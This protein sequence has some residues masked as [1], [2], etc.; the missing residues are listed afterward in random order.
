MKDKDT[1]KLAQYVAL[2]KTIKRYGWILKG[3]K[4][5]ESVADHVFSVIFIAMILSEK[6]K[7]DHEKV[8]KMAIIH[9]IGKAL[10]G[11]I[12]YEHGTETVA[13]LRVKIADE[14]AAI[15]TIFKH[16]PNKQE[17]LTLW[18]ERAE[19]KTPEALFVKRVE[20]LEMAMQALEYENEGYESELFDEFW[21]NARKY[22]AGTELESILNELKAHRRKNL[23]KKK[24]FDF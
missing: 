2:L 21:E 10:I 4:N 22:L 13:P 20:K 24:G 19:Q 11:D 8:L 18:E 9:D 15:K 6:T 5:G 17:Y 23:H 12:I 3:V 16:W 14:R 1:I 7:L